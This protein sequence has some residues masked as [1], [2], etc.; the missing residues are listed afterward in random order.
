MPKSNGKRKF[1][2]SNGMEIVRSNPPIAARKKKYMESLV[3]F[4]KTHPGVYYLV[5]KYSNRGSAHSL[6]SN[7]RKAK[8]VARVDKITNK[9]MVVGVW[10]KFEAK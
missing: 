3:P 1:T 8:M 7:L 9:P 6:A 10:A 4:L 5:N 2:L